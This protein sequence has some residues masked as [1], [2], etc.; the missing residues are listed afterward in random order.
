MEKE[1]IMNKSLIAIGL[2]VATSLAMPAFA[3]PGG[4]PGVNGMQR[5]AQDLN[6]SAEQQKKIEQIRTDSQDTMKAMRDAMLANRDA[7]QKLDPA[8]TDFMAQTDKLAAEK[9]ALVEGM[10]KARAKTQ[11]DIAAVLTPEQR[12]KH[13]ELRKQ[14]Q[15]QRKARR[16]ERRGDREKGRGGPGRGPGPDD[17][18]RGMGM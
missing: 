13:A 17:G 3:C 2:L 8:A 11:A 6:L 4:G 12:A 18:P 14:R 7:T 15:E 10:M 9:G 5:M 16:D 1:N